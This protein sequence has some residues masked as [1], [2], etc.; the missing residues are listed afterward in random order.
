MRQ[1]YGEGSL[2]QLLSDIDN[3]IEI[4]LENGSES[5]ESEN[6]GGELQS[7][8]K[9]AILVAGNTSGSDLEKALPLVPFEEKK[10]FPLHNN[11]YCEEIAHLHLFT[12]RKFGC[13][14][15]REIPLSPNKYVKQRLLNF[16]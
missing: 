2:A 8:V 6:E 3:P 10:P 4:V 14:V 11:T 1:L 16:S 9:E 15:I 7:F 13:K 5:N 12:T